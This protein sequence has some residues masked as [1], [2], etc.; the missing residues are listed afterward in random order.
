[1]SS[2][3]QAHVANAQVEPSALVELLAS[4]YDLAAPLACEFLRRGFNDHYAVTAGDERYVLRVYLNGKY[5]I[6][7]ERDFQFE[8]DL[9]AFLRGRDLPVAYALPRR[10]GSLMGAIDV[11]GGQRHVAL[12]SFAEGQEAERISPQQGAKLGETVAAFHHAANDHQSSHP[13][14]H[15]NLE[16]L[17]ERPMALIAPLLRAR[18]CSDLDRY[19]R[20]ADAVADQIRVLPAIGDEYGLIHGDLHKGNFF[21]DARDRPT[22][23]DFDH[24]GYGWRSYDLA[25]CKGSLADEAWEAFLGAYQA[26]R[27]L[28]EAEL[29]MIPVFRKI[30]PIWDKGDILAMNAAWGEAGLEDEYYDVITRMFEKLTADGD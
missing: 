22:L 18:G 28:S 10:D 7:S 5:Y 29:Q 11:P 17:L 9:L 12:F 19:Q 1:M 4:D 16:Y 26:L 13:R 23:F 20:F 25:V 15:L 30:R 8:L 21:L 27:P 2:D 24:C 6:S 3:P 14:Y